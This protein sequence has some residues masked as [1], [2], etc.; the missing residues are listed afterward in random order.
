[1]MPAAE[2][3]DSP[4]IVPP[5]PSKTES[6]PDPV[7]KPVQAR[8]RFDAFREFATAC[9]RRE[10]TAKASAGSPDALENNVQQLKTALNLIERSLP[11]CGW[12]I[13]GAIEL[14]RKTSTR[15]S[16]LN[17]ASKLLDE[18]DRTKPVMTPAKQFGTRVREALAEIDL[19]PPQ[20]SK[21]MGLGGST[22][23][24]WMSG[25]VIP[26]GNKANRTAAA[27]LEDMANK[28]NY[29]QPLLRPTWETVD[30]PAHIP[31][32]QWPRVLER[33]RRGGQCHLKGAE[34]SQKIEEILRTP[35]KP[36]RPPYRLP[37]DLKRWP[38]IPRAE[39]EAYKRLAQLRSEPKWSRNP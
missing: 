13:E 19:K 12:S 31:E 39:F 34:L 33:L 18:F 20:V 16:E 27:A 38:P 36:Q 22:I 28:P 11:E 15:P 37:Q 7:L 21:A 32:K 25:K 29:L 1:M 26:L 10:L 24:K 2:L 4:S 8:T 35:R 23:Y 14:A 6:V 9:R 30:R 3:A 17:R 5:D